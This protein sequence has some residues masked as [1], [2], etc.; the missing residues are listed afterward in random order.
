MVSSRDVNFSLSLVVALA[1]VISCGDA[2]APTSTTR[3]GIARTMT[4]TTTSS[5][6]IVVV[7]AAG[8]SSHRHNDDDDVTSV[9]VATEGAGPG[10]HANIVGSWIST[11]A[12][13]AF[14]WSAPA[15]MMTMSQH[16]GG[17][18]GFDAA[19]SM[20]SSSYVAYAKE[21]ASGSGTRV[22]KDPES[23]LRYGLPIDNVE[24][25]P[26]V[27]RFVVVAYVVVQ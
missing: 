24:V 10:G 7:R 5:S 4:T 15:S 9:P 3:A 25:R 23:L 26:R 20:M 14:L 27:S 21:M 12:L 13:S 6:S 11:V 22:N 18:G 16:V 17:G 19:N 1:F 8:S 2:F